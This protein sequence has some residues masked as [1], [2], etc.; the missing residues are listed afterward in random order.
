MAPVPEQQP[1][2]GVRGSLTAVEAEEADRGCYFAGLIE[3]IEEAQELGLTRRQV[4][5]RAARVGLG[6][7]LNP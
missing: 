2:V 1:R 7:T 4:I 6:V 5:E 3:I